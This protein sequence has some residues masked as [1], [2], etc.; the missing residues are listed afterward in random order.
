MRQGRSAFLKE[1]N[2]PG[3]PPC[4]GAGRG[5]DGA[6]TQFASQGRK[7]CFFEKKQQKTF[8]HFGFGLSGLAQPSFAKVFWFFFSKKNCFLPRGLCSAF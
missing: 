2:C 8:D 7:A 3:P 4:A 1:S 6:T 5:R